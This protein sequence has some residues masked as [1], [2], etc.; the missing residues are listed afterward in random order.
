MLG[1]LSMVRERYGSVE[2]YV[3]EQLGV[4]QASVEQI[5]KNLIVEDDEPLDWKRHVELAQL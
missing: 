2:R 5:R 3:V 4:S 1:T